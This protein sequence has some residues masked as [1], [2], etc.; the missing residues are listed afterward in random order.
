M[1]KTMKETEKIAKDRVQPNQNTL[2]T[3]EELELRFA[4]A[5]SK[6]MDSFIKFIL[7]YIGISVIAI[8]SINLYNLYTGKLIS[9]VVGEQLSVFSGE[10]F[11][12][13]YLEIHTWCI[14]TGLP[15]A[16]LSPFLF[17]FWDELKNFWDKLKKSKEKNS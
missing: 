16:L 15:V 13:N 12:V 6:G 9:I 3:E 2:P 14:L 10:F 17:N 11:V 8:T 1:N 5:Y 7:S 4:T